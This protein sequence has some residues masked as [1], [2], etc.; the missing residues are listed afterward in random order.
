MT[1]ARKNE[2]TKE[3]NQ[4]LD[5]ELYIVIRTNPKIARQLAIDAVTLCGVRKIVM[6][7]NI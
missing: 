6:P 2:K 1:S 3:S 4:D 7:C 5:I